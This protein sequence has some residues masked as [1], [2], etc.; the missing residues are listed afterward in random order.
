MEASTLIRKLSGEVKLSYDERVCHYQIKFNNP[1][2][3]N[4]ENN[5]IDD[6]FWKKK[7]LINKQ[8]I[9]IFQEF[10]KL[11]KEQGIKLKQ[12]VQSIINQEK[13]R[14]TEE[15][16]KFGKV[17]S[18]NDFIDSLLYI[19]SN[20]PEFH[21]DRKHTLLLH[22]NQI[23]PQCYDSKSHFVLTKIN[24]VPQTADKFTIRDMHPIDR[25]VF[26]LFELKKQSASIIDSSS[27]ITEHQLIL[28]C[29]DYHKLHLES[30]PEICMVCTDEELQ[31]F[32]KHE[33][34]IRKSRNKYL[35][36]EVDLCFSNLNIDENSLE[37]LFKET[38]NKKQQMQS[39]QQQQFEPIPNH[40]HMY[41]GICNTKYKDYIIHKESDE[42]KLNTKCQKNDELFNKQQPKSIRKSTLL[43]QSQSQGKPP[44][45]FLSNLD[46]S[47]NQIQQ[48]QQMRKSMGSNQKPQH[49]HFRHNMASSYLN[50][51]KRVQSSTPQPNK[52]DLNNNLHRENKKRKNDQISQTNQGVS[53]DQEN[54]QINMTQ[55]SNH[56]RIKL[57]LENKQNND[58]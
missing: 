54:D 32:K 5:C 51:Q 22:E 38:G 11:C 7:H 28:D 18:L 14:F 56:K 16:L 4:K 21:F 52:T 13:T 47:S 15:E 19:Y 45:S 57:N 39:Q 42:H 36:Q 9:R 1:Y 43:K 41:C 44:N 50:L 34:K 24:S 20:Y 53:D 8:N 6:I 12:Q 31:Y 27:Q 35:Q 2:F 55:Q 48:Q 33:D 30:P 29:Y 46:K 58:S 26:H 40:A 25:Q 49:Q 10:D 17:I 37:L 23:Q 3:E